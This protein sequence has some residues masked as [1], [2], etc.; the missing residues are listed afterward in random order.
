[1]HPL[2][3]RPD[4]TAGRGR[5]SLLAASA[6]LLAG[7]VLPWPTLARLVA[8]ASPVRLGTAAAA[9]VCAVVAL[10]VFGPARG[11]PAA[12]M[13]RPLRPIA[14]WWMLAAAAVVVALSWG[15]TAWM[16]AQANQVTPAGERAKA[17]IDAVRT[18]LATGAGIGAGTALLLAFRRQ[19]HAEAAAAS[20]DHDASEKRITELYTKAV[21]QL[22]SD[23]APVRLGGLYALER[24]GQNHPDHRQVVVDVICAYLRMPYTPPDDDPAP[25]GAEPAGGADPREE[26]QVRLTAQ[27]ILAAHLRTPTPL[28]AWRSETA[29]RDL[30]DQ[31]TLDLTGA[32][33][34]NLDFAQCRLGEV[35]FYGATFIGTARFD[36]ATFTGPAWF[37]RATFTGDTAFSWAAFHGAMAFGAATFL[38]RADFDGTSVGH[39][40]TFVAATFHREASFQ[41]STFTG[42]TTFDRAS[43]RGAATFRHATFEAEATFTDAT[44]GADTGFDHAEFRGRTGLAADY[45]RGVAFREATFADVTSFKG[46]VF[47]GR[48]ADLRGARAR[49]AE[50]P[51]TWPNGWSTIEDDAEFHPLVRLG[52]PPRDP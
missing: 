1:M 7:A 49:T 16:L 20:T 24:L 25:P 41:L 28:E 3:R 34:I 4:G 42:D 46:A 45:R 51:N 52:G 5:N 14:W 6:V 43:F 22:G 44:F 2:R 33:L 23:R 36:G 47:A 9:V 12:D 38:R 17:R 13:P 15:V 21:E 11:R 31:V 39:D 37:N 50:G 8:D 29:E 32:T 10:T 35:N 26:H 40:A 18:G 48:A 30:W 19:H 27:R